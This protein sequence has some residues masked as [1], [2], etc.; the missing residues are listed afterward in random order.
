MG[1]IYWQLNDI[2]PVAS[3]ASI[4]YHGRWKALHY[5][6]K[7]FFAPVLLSCL[8]QGET[9][10]RKTVVQQPSPVSVTAS[11][12]VSNERLTPF[13]GVVRWSLRGPDS[14]IMQEG[15]EN[16]RVPA[17]ESRWIDTLDFGDADYLRSHLWYELVKD[18][19]TVSSGSVLFT[20]PKHYAFEDPA[21][22]CSADGDTITV[23]AKA[24]A[25][26]VEIYGGEGD[27]LLSDNFF[28][29]EK[30][31][32]TVTVLQ[33]SPADLRVRSVFDIR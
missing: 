14:L 8:E 10:S 5:A 33:G 30:G 28:D 16:V 27:L 18:G 24:Y 26:F 7:R 22:T 1:A 3:W 31:E 29:M 23:T 21:L 12:N 32:K 11:L 13:D 15:E 17:M 4:D 6:A 9:T 19:E 25:R 2:W 20:A